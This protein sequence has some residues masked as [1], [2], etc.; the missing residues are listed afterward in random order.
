MDAQEQYENASLLTG[1]ELRTIAHKPEIR[2]LS[3]LSLPEIDAA[4]DLIARIAP[5]GNVPGV[6]A[7]RTE[8]RGQD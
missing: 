1:S 4:V 5:A 6:R 8:R 7:R 3:S 2:D